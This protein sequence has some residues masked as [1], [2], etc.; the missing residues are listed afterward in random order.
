MNTTYIA[1]A[2]LKINGS[3][4][5]SKLMESVLQISIEQSL[6]LPAMFTLIIQNSRYPGDPDDKFWQHEKEFEIGTEIEIGFIGSSTEDKDFSD[7]EEGSVIKGEVT[8]IE[9]QFTTGSQAPMIIRGYDISH[10]L[11]RGRFNRSFQ[12]ATDSDIIKK[13]IGEVGI[14]S[15][16]IDSTSPTHEYVF[17]ENQTNM[18]FFRERAARNGYELFVQDG[19]L[20]FRKPKSEATIELEWLK[21]L[22]D[23]RV[24]VSSAEQVSS[25]EVRGWD[26]TK[27]E[28][29]VATKNADKVLTETDYGKGKKSSSS[30]SG[31]PT[32]PKVIVVDQPVSSTSE[33]EKIAQSLVDELGGEFVIADARAEGNPDICP[34][35]IIKLKDM[36][37]YSGS[38]YV[39]ETRHLYENR[40]YTTEFSVRGLRGGDLLATLSPPTRLK[41]GQTLMVGQVTDNNDPKKWGRVRV[42]FPTLTPKEGKDAHTSYWARVVAIGA[43]KDRGFDCLPEVDDEVLVAFEHGDIHRPYVVGGVWNGKDAPPTV[44]TDSVVDGKVRLR[45]FK[46][47]IGH[48]L[49]FVEEDKDSTKQGIYIDTKEKNYLH[50]NDTDQF[51]ELKT[52]NGH[53]VLLDDKNEKILV[54]SKGGHQTL[55]DDKGKKIEIK[56]SGG[57][58]VK[59]DDNGKKIEI[60]STGDINLTAGSGKNI[61][62]DATKINLTGKTGINLKVSGNSLDIAAASVT[63]K[64]SATMTVQGLTTTIKGTTSVA[65]SSLSIKLG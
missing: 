38:Y 30:F 65:V 29:I 44:V 32:S 42:W 18:E 8:A 11:H 53:Q 41:P 51:I 39:T 45:T 23:F 25:V 17:Q 61:N 55:L 50:F 10:R 60:T 24:R 22:Y 12:D 64:S 34:G 49:Q 58:L 48:Q 26:Y 16:T 62:L 37:K 43:G 35:K 13:I 14:T 19:K 52:K 1:Q 27:K 21:D 9:T 54:K 59:L 5:S 57:H 4:A 31:K 56:S 33:V 6:H 47:R 3:K 46:T 63:L 7:V 2:T 36:S 28:A 20:N 15:K 40:V